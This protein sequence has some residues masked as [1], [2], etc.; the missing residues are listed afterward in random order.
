MKMNRISDMYVSAGKNVPARTCRIFLCVLLC[1]A[2]AGVLVSCGSKTEDPAAAETKQNETVFAVN[3]YV[4]QKGNLDDYLEFGGD[5]VAASSVDI[6]PETSG[7]LSAVYVSVGS[8]VRK[9]QVIAEVDPSRPGMTYSV[10]PIKAPI[11]GTITSLPVPVGST[12]GPTMSVGKVSNT[13]KLEISMSVAERFVSRIK[14]GQT[15]YLQFD[16]YP[17]EQFTAK[18]T[19]ISPVLDT[20]TRTMA[21]TLQLD[22]PDSRIKAGM[23]AR[24]RLITDTKKDIIVIPNSAIVSR[25]GE[26]YVFI[27]DKTG[28][29]S[30]VAR[31][32]KVTAGIRV[33]DM[34]EILSG[35]KDGE[36]VVIKGQTLLENGSK[37]NIVSETGG[38]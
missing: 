17:G 38:M 16:A 9:D 35:I 5:V 22:P 30:A 19:K 13:D 37:L 29:Q 25:Q 36:S 31:R 2:A 24:I 15:A 12:V 26:T 32:E 21:V 14:M 34:T 4:A 3:T 23:F 27:A 18:V 11:S 20:T 6:L 8:T 33:D 1:C 10:S 7:K 28:G